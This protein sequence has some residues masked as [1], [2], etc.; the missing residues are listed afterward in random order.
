LAEFKPVRESAAPNLE[1]TKN[2]FQV[3]YNLDSE[4]GNV[5]YNLIVKTF[6]PKRPT[7]QIEASGIES[8]NKIEGAPFYGVRRADGTILTASTRNSY[9]CLITTLKP[10]STNGSA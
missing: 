2:S 7:L 1:T 10:P 9:R 8:H 4:G 6:L 5:E 3:S